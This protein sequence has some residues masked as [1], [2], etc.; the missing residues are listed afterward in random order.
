MDTIFVISRKD[1][2]HLPNTS[3]NQTPDRTEQRPGLK[4]N[5]KIKKLN[6]CPICKQEFNSIQDLKKHVFNPCGKRSNG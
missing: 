5:S 3:R 1:V 2:S 6:V 4:S